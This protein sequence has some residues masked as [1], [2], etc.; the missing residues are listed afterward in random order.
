M[1]MIPQENIQQA[2][3]GL[4]AIAHEVRLSVLCHLMNGPM[5]VNEL[6][7]ATGSSQSNL[8]QHLAKMR[9]LGIIANEKRGQQVYYRITNPQFK[10]LV[11][12]LKHIYCPEACGPV[13]GEV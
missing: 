5:C 1:E 11:H 6:I 13:S 9:M 2:S 7:Q 3:E 12:V 10:E 4:R 8:S